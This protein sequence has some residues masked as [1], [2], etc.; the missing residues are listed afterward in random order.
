MTLHATVAVGVAGA[1]G[2]SRTAKKLGNSVRKL[3]AEVAVGVR[4]DVA[5]GSLQ[6]DVPIDKD[7]GSAF[8]STFGRSDHDIARRLNRPV[9]SKM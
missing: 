1:G 5:W 7:D 3:R 4:E 2:G 6:G 9:K 8:V